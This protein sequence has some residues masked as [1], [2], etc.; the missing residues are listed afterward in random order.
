MELIPCSLEKAYWGSYKLIFWYILCC[1]EFP[2]SN[3]SSGVAWNQFP[4]FSYWQEIPLKLAS[5]E[6]L[7]EN[8]VEACLMRNAWWVQQN[9]AFRPS[10]TSYRVVATSHIYDIYTSDIYDIYQIYIYIWYIWYIWVIASS[11]VN[12][13]KLPHCT[14]SALKIICKDWI[15]NYDTATAFFKLKK[16]MENKQYFQRRSL[17]WPGWF[18]RRQRTQ[19]SR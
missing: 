11:A 6:M 15:K 12:Q 7:P 13:R 5:S 19:L 17:F 4:T 8:S 16:K 18:N 10:L 3:V 9:P 2:G 1:S 14:I